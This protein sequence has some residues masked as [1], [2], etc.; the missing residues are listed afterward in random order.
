MIQVVVGDILESRAQTLVNTVNCVGVMGKGIALAFRDR[1]PDMYRDYVARCHRGEVKLGRPYLFRSLLP[2]W[3]LNFP[4]KNHWRSVARL[5]DIARG[6]EYLNAHYKEWGIESLAVPPLGCGQGGLEWKIVGKT[7]YRYLKQLEV[8]VELYAPFDV[9]REQLQLSFLDDDAGMEASTGTSPW[10]KVPP[11]LVAI[12]EIVDRL[13]RQPYH[14]PVGRTI[15]Q[16]IAYFATASGVPT[17]LSFQRGSYGPYSEAL[18]VRETQLVNN[19]LVAEELQG[20]MLR[21]RPGRALK[22][23]VGA[24]ASSLGQWES[25]VDRIADLFMRMD[26]RVAEVAAT[27]HFATQEIETRLGRAPTEQEVLDE[28]MLWKQR[29]NP[30]IKREEVARA[31]RNLATHGWLRVTPSR[32]LPVPDDDGLPF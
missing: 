23:A 3:V 18:K 20:N 19:G 21:I 5:D 31:V 13:D 1:F 7:L 25:V 32:E 22:D 10:R 28:V 14:T 8:S 4:T 17:G 15:F 9:P 30:P 6:L 24:Y 2:P 12:A 27:V 29:R 26:T 11:G 16:K